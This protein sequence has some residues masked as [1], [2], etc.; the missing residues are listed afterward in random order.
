MG[1]VLAPIALPI[2]EGI[3]VPAWQRLVVLRGKY[4]LTAPYVTKHIPVVW[5]HH[6]ACEQPN[7]YKNIPFHRTVF[8][9]K[10]IILGKTHDPVQIPA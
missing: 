8:I 4:T 6:F 2:S 5:C 9:K 1:G 3:H 10:I 7:F